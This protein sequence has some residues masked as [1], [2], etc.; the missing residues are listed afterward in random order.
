MRRLLPGT[1]LLTLTGPAGVGKTRL[2][3]RLADDVRDRAPARRSRTGCASSPW[4][5]W[6]IRRWC[7]RRWR[8]RWACP[9]RPAGPLALTLADALRPR[10]LLLVLDNCEHLVDACAR[11]ADALLR[12]CP[13]LTILATSREALGIAG[14]TVWP[15]PPLALPAHRGAL[16]ALEALARYRGGARCSSTGRAPSAGL[17]ADRRQRARRG[18]DLRPARRAPLAIELAAARV[19][20]LPPEQLLPAPGRPLPAADGRQPHRAPAASRRCGR[21]WTG[22]TPCSPPAERTLFARLAVFAGGFDPGGRRGGGRRG[23]ASTAGRRARPA[24]APG[25]PVAGGGGGAAGRRPPAT[26]CWRRCASTPGS[27]SRRGRRGRGRAR[28]A[29]ALL[30]GLRGARRRGHLRRGEQLAWFARLDREHD[31]VRA[32]LRWCAERGQA[33]DAARRAGAAGRRALGDLYWFVRGHFREGRAWLEALL[34]LPPAAAHLRPGAG[35]GGAGVA[36]EP[37]HEPVRGRGRALPGGARDRARGGRPPGRRRRPHRARP[38]DGR[39]RGPAGAPARGPRAVPRVGRRLRDRAGVLV[40]RRDG[41][42]RGDR[43]RARAYF[44]EGLAAARADGER[45]GP[46]WR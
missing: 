27:S 45:M 16:P 23:R 24:D 4:R 36:A 17:R 37:V 5:R 22:A 20:V 46:R 10:C 21:R 26:G 15:V 30:P 31:N 3:L 35:A 25:G 6:P 40:P 12:A 19:R 7:P 39:P 1:R 44:E 9:R 13:R 32:A 18:A 8:R 14:E 11:L 28:G 41:A 43:A 42:C 38:A 34:A 2:A 33:G 29:R